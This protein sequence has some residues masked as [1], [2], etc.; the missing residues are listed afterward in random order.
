VELALVYHQMDSSFPFDGFYSS[1]LPIYVWL[2]ARNTGMQFTTRPGRDATC[3][4]GNGGYLFGREFALLHSWQNATK[5]SRES[6]Q[7]WTLTNLSRQ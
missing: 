6:V 1:K 4:A 2:W 3:R 7:F 5:H